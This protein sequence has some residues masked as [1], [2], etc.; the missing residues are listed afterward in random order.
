MNINHL[1]ANTTDPNLIIYSLQQQY[2]KGGPGIV[3]YVPFRCWWIKADGT[4]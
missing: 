4:D 2:R 3:G 1:Q